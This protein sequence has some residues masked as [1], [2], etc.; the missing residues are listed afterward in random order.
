[1]PNT[2]ARPAASG[3]TP[4]AQTSQQMFILFSSLE[5]YLLHLHTL[6]VCWERPFIPR[7]NIEEVCVRSAIEEGYAV[8][9]LS[10][11]IT[12]IN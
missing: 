9:L 12:T 5:M 4:Q 10:S 6:S 11:S 2:L 3:T 7:S 8:D 1:M